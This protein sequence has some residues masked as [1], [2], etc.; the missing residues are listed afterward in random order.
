MRTRHTETL[1]K[2]S[3]AISDT[4]RTEEL[5]QERPPGVH[6]QR[7]QRRVAQ[8]VAQPGNRLPVSIQRTYQLGFDLTHDGSLDEPPAYGGRSITEIAG[9]CL[10]ALVRSSLFVASLRQF[11]RFA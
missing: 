4:R 2:A 10:P 8:R 1:P 5:P 11:P 6:K 7:P 3:I 9:E